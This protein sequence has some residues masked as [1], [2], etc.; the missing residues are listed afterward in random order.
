MSRLPI[1]LSALAAALPKIA[2]YCETTVDPRLDVVVDDDGDDNTTEVRVYAGGTLVHIDR[3]KHRDDVAPPTVRFHLVDSGAWDDTQPHDWMETVIAAAAN[4]PAAV[5]SHIADRAREYHQQ[6]GT[7]CG[8]QR[9]AACRG[10]VVDFFPVIVTAKAPASARPILTHPGLRITRADQVQPGDLIVSDF[11]PLAP[12]Q[13][14]PTTNYV[15]AGYYSAD[16]QPYD[17]TC[18]CGVCETTDY[19]NG[20]VVLSRDDV[21]PDVCDPFAADAPVLVLP[22]DGLSDAASTLLIS[23]IELHNRLFNICDSDGMN[24]GDTVDTVAQW[25]NEL[26]IPLPEPDEDDC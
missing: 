4:A 20:A 17:P 11:T 23:V 21:W 12:G 6:C 10:P 22:A 3:A 24:G 9:A 25:F 15:A 26:G 5:R 18:E 2:G 19:P 7:W 8:P 14:T 13:T 16:P 1:E